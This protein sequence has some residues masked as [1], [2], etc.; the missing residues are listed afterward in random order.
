MR[1]YWVGGEVG[2]ITMSDLSPQMFER[3]WLGKTLGIEFRELTLTRVVAT[4]PI[5]PTHHQPYGYLHGG[6]SVSLAESVASVGGALNCTPGKGVVG[7]EIN[8]NHVR[9]RRSGMLTAIGMPLHSGQTTHVWEIKIYD[10]NQK[11]VCV[12]RCTLAVVPLDQSADDT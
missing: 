4:M 10:Q 6:A 1:M 3:E 2:A 12:S 7:L 9:P 5:T 11:L 8:A